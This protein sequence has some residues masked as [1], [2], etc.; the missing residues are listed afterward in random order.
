VVTLPADAIRPDSGRLCFDALPGTIERALT[1]TGDGPALPADAAG[2]LAERWERVLLVYLDAFGWWLYEQAAAHPLFRR[3]VHEVQLTSQFP[4]TTT[5][6]VTTINTGL[7]VGEHGLYEWF[8]YEPSLDRLIC[9]LLYAYAGDGRR[10][11][12]APTL[13]PDELFPT[14]TIYRRLA[15]ADVR[16]AA[17][18]PAAFTHS[19]PNRV[20]L[21]GADV[22]AFRSP[23]E[24]VAQ[25]VHAF[26]NGARYGYL[27]LGEVDTLMHEQGPASPQVLPLLRRLLT[28]IEGLLDALP[29]GTLVLLTSD[30]GMAPISP[31]T[32]VYLN[33]LWPELEHLLRHGADGKPLAPA[34]SARDL[35]LHTAGARDEVVA[36]LGE[37]L[38]GR[39]TVAAVDELVA[40]GVF[41]PSTGPRLLERLGDVVVLP[42][43][44]E[45]VYWLEP[46][47]FTQDL[48]GMHGGLTAAELLV[49]LLAFT[50]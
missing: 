18:Q 3:A 35:F 39:A 14:G 45:S 43:L 34:G 11:T 9:P 28:T 6:H 19:P 1:G 29:Q 47:R 5:A 36:G 7:P 24:G 2:V 27:Y 13:A 40:D 49:P 22:F 41:G 25:L 33:V 38:A 44:G 50:A 46:G 26:A 16:S 10:D 48:H 23:R 20:L 37:R 31:E 42:A 21:D 4:S 12:L 30:H 32:T 15:A 8:V 17:A